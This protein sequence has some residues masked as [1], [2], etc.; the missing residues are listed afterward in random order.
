MT[1]LHV[2]YWTVTKNVLTNIY[3][4]FNKTE[5]KLILRAY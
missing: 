5:I 4:K 2:L 3:K 1:N